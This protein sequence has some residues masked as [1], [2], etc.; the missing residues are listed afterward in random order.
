M[1]GGQAPLEALYD[2]DWVARLSLRDLDRY[3][4]NY[5]GAV[6]QIQQAVQLCRSLG[7][8]RGEM[9]CLIHLADPLLKV[10]DYAAAQQACA[11]GLA[12]ARTLH[13]RWGEAFSLHH[14][15]NATRLLGYYG[16]AQRLLESAYA[17]IQA[18]SDLAQVNGNGAQWDY[19]LDASAAQTKL[20][21]RNSRN[22]IVRELP[23][24]VTAGTHS[25]AW[26]G[27]DANGLAVPSGTYQLGVQATT[28]ADTAIGSHVSISGR[29]GA[30]EQNNGTTQL[31]VNGLPVGLDRISR[32]NLP[33][34]TLTLN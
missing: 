17:I 32:I 20:V 23:G 15:G 7:K 33:A 1:P 28:A 19:T 12:L 27:R 10:H 31:L 21:I 8:T 4:D 9:V 34:Q 25:L 5:P 11:Q 26:D 18:D 3:T 24:E 6:A 29:V 16:E 13:N 22:Q 30:I 14:L 2:A